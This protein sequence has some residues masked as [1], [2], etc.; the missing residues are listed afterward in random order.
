MRVLQPPSAGWKARAQRLIFL[1]SIGCSFSS[2]RRFGCFQGQSG[3][4]SIV[5]TQC[6]PFCIRFAPTISPRHWNVS[7]LDFYIGVFHTLRPARASLASDLMEEFRSSVERL[8]IGAVNL[9]IVQAEDFETQV[10]GAVL[11]NGEGRKKVI[12][13][14]QNKKR[15]VVMHPFLK[16]KIGLKSAV[17]ITSGS[18]VASHPVRGAWIEM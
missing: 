4:R 1:C 16:E 13:L 7:G 3:R 10:S 18:I 11:L 5:R 9:K 6:F 15:E 8:V 2:E 17:S 14:W 12:T